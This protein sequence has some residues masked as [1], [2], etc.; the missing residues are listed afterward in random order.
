M[1]KCS[2]NI[3]TIHPARVQRGRPMNEKVEENPMD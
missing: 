2:M 3:K 1:L